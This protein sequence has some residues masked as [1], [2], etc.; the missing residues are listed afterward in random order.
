M[1]FLRFPPYSCL[2]LKYHWVSLQSVQYRLSALIPSNITPLCSLLCV[3]VR[4]V[5]DRKS[6]WFPAE[7]LLSHSVCACV[8]VVIII[9]SAPSSEWPDSLRLKQEGST[10][11]SSPSPLTPAWFSLDRGHH[12]PTNHYYFS[13]ISTSTLRSHS[14][15]P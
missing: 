10:I 5:L 7:C 3:R 6:A 4:C 11:H 9:H 13:H 1:H 8:C 14:R 2:L 15:N 12:R